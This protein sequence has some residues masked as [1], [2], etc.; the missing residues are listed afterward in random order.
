MGVEQERRKEWW[1]LVESNKGWPMWP[2]LLLEHVVADEAKIKR[3]KKGTLH[4]CSGPHCWP[5][6][7]PV[8]LY[9]WMQVSSLRQNRLSE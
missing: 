4:K 7:G 1:H 5:S 3:G 2:A 9:L 6:R 8:H